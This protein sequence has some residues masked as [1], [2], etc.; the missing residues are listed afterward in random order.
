MRLHHVVT[1]AVGALA[2]AVGAGCTTEPKK[3]ASADQFVGSEKCGTCHVAEYNSWKATNHAKMVRPAGEALLRDAG[4]NW[5]KDSKGNAG[6]TKANITGTPAKM[7]DVVY[8]VGSYWK[9]RYLVK[10]PNTGNHQFLDKQ[11][12]RMTK[13]WEP[14][15]QKNDWETVCATCHATGYTLTAYDPKEPAKQKFKMSEHNTGCES[16]HGPGAK[17]VASRSK[18]DVFNPAKATKEQSSLV[19]GYCHVRKENAFFKTAQGHA[20][21]DQP[22]P[23]LGESYKAGTDDW[24]TWYPDKMLIPGALPG[25]PVSKNYP[26]TDLN[27]AFFLD[28]KA[29]Q[30]DSYDARKH[31]Q[32][33]QEYTQSAHYKKNLLACSDCHSPHSVPNK[34]KIEA[35]ATCKGC[36]GDAYN[37]DKIMPGLA[38]TAVGLFMRSHTFNKS[39]DRPGGLTATGEPEYYYTR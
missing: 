25:Q 21:E 19:C 1:L 6:P 33:W 7:E 15:G 24:R 11:W 23:M 4:V 35:K 31:H 38:Q 9:Q 12:N 5:A 34:A 16:C 32:E 28:D 22:H 37:V 30:W 10:N 8:V 13:V 2:L 17:H 36:H 3:V 26:D 20:R 18:A 14:Y 39:Q 27:N 29:K